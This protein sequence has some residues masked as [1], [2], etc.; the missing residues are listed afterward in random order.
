MILQKILEIFL[1]CGTVALVVLICKTIK[2]LEERD[3]K[4][5]ENGKE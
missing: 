2:V 1:M 3:R 5:K 4:D